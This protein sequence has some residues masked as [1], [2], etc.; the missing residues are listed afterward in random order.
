MLGRAFAHTF[1]KA[2][3][4]L[5][6]ARSGNGRTGQ[7][8]PAQQCLQSQ[9]CSE[10]LASP[11]LRRQKSDLHSVTRTG[12]HLALNF[13]MPSKLKSQPGHGVACWQK[14]Q[15]LRQAKMSYSLGDLSSRP[16]CGVVAC[17][18]DQEQVPWEKLRREDS[19]APKASGS[20]QGAHSPCWHGTLPFAKPLTMALHVKQ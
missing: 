5:D 2:P 4:M 19:K 17:K 3:D 18:E 16:A 7:P 12:L 11:R 10:M 6:H 13:R 9:F 15:S 8:L 20:C 14:R 1:I